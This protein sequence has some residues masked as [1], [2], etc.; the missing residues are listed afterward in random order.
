MTGLMISGAENVPLSRGNVDD[1]EEEE[2]AVC[3]LEGAR[4]VI[5]SVLYVGWDTRMVGG[6]EKGV[7]TY[8]CEAN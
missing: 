6:A 7:L 1:D 8:A 2:G 4:R 3:G 5:A